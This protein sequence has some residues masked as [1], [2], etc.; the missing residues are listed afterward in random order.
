MFRAALP[1]V[2]LLRFVDRGTV[3]STVRRP[4]L[5]LRGCICSFDERTEVTT[6]SRDVAE[7]AG[8]LHS[9]NGCALH[10]EVY[11]AIVSNHN[12]RC[13][14]WEIERRRDNGKTSILTSA[15]RLLCSRE[16][17]RRARVALITDEM[18]GDWSRGT[19]V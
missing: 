8:S 5:S 12:S 11:N 4:H 17:R 2:L 10:L 18:I 15:N 16:D 3:F 9:M 14:I 1:V 19:R 13:F 6:S 7:V